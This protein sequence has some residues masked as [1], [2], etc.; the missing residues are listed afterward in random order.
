MRRAE[1]F[2]LLEGEKLT[3]ADEL[4]YPD[5]IVERTMCAHLPFGVKAPENYW[6]L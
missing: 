4:S 2:H 6:A 3:A 5:V 1:L